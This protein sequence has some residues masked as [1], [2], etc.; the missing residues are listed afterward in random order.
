[1]LRKKVICLIILVALSILT[2]AM[3]WAQPEGY[4]G[5]KPISMLIPFPAGGGSDILGR[6]IVSLDYQYFGTNV[7]PVIKSG[8]TGSI[9][10]DYVY[11]S[12]PDGYTLLLG[13]PHMITLLPHIRKVNY[14][15][16]KMT[17]I[18]CI[19]ESNSFAITPKDRPWSTWEEFVSHVR[20]NPGKYSYGS[21]GTWGIT[22]IRIAAILKSLGLKMVHVPYG[23]GSQVNQALIRGEVD[24]GISSPSH[25]LPLIQSGDLKA[26]GAVLVRHKALPD[27]P[28]FAELGI[29]VTMPT[30]RGVIAPPDTPKEIVDWLESKFA[31]LVKDK[32][33]VSTMDKLGEDIVYIP[34]DEWYEKIKKEYV[35]YGDV[36]KSI[37]EE[38]MQKK[39]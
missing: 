27:V 1:M 4:P 31:V 13:A 19:N 33:F 39:K 14:D 37:A 8:A 28:S 16:L 38:E 21:T 35:D 9:A 22:H 6:I 20:K 12:K 17:Y 15:P 5:N 25:V 36:I 7:V 24:F 23:G 2:G 30:W 11:H 10:T 32:S 29:S 18:C 34:K 26:L 3:A